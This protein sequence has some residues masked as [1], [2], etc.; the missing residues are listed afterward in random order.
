MS[1]T[2]PDQLTAVFLL[3][4]PLFGHLYNLGVNF[5][6]VRATSNLSQFLRVSKTYNV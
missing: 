6:D 4:Y 1:G 3:R 5:G 2:K